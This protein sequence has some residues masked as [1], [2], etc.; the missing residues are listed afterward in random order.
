MEI[1]EIVIGIINSKNRVDFIKKFLRKNKIEFRE[2]SYDAGCNIEVKINGTNDGEIIFLAH[3][4]ISMGTD[5][6]ANDNTSSVAV[7]LSLLLYLKDKSPFYTIKIVFNDK[8]EFVG[9]LLSGSIVNGNMTKIIDKIGSFDYIKNHFSK[10]K[11]KGIFILELSGIGDAVLI[12]KKSGKIDCSQRL[13]DFATKVAKNNNFKYIHLPVPYT[14]M[15]SVHT[16]HY[17]GVVLTIVPYYE[18]LNYANNK[19]TYPSIWN[20]IHSN[21]DNIFT[22]QEKSLNLMLNFVIN[23]IENL[24]LLN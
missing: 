6:G 10:G 21:K 19:D 15:V 16:F 24:S 9:G 4:D 14:D 20:N 18:A 22:I 17:E 1:K 5:E 13:I 12:A 7:L 2:L 11:N 8:E 23:L 3:Y